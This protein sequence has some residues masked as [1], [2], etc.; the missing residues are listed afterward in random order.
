[1]LFTSPEKKLRYF[2]KG[3]TGSNE[4]EDDYISEGLTVYCITEFSGWKTN[5]KEMFWFETFIFIS[6]TNHTK[7]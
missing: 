2:F 7:C 5:A 4:D 1:M 6:S 3:F